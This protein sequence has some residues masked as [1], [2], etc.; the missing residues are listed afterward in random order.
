M[1]A[2]EARGFVGFAMSAEEEI[3]RETARP[4]TCEDELDQ[5]KKGGHLTFGKRP[6]MIMFAKQPG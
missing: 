2:E 3:L 1:S 4:F 5:I 6:P